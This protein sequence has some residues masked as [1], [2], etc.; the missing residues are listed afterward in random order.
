MLK[1]L[2]G[3]ENE[4]Q[5]TYIN[6]DKGESIR[7]VIKERNLNRLFVLYFFFVNPLLFASCTD[8]FSKWCKI[9][10]GMKRSAQ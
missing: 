7:R 6:K 1:K 5:G 2:K 4:K 8:T 10:R 3:K 9:T